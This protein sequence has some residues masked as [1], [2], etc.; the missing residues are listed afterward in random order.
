MSLRKSS[1]ERFDETMQNKMICIVGPTASGKTALSIA[2]AKE[3][4]AEIISG[5]S[6]QIYRGM[7]IGTAKPTEE[8]MDGV[9]HHMLSIAS[10]SENFSVARYV[11][12]ASCI[13]DDIISRGKIP[14][15]VGGTGLYI[16]SLVRGR[17]FAKNEESGALREELTKIYEK[18]GAD[19]LHKMLSELDPARAAEIHKNNVKRVIR[20]IEVCKLSGKTITEHDEETKKIPPKYDAAYIGIEFADRSALWE[21][22]HL[23]VDMMMAE[24]LLDEVKMLLDSGIST[25]TTAMQAIGYK[26]LCAYFAGDKTLADAVE[27]IKTA[28]RRYAKRQMTW[29]KRNGSIKWVSPDLS[30]KFPD[31]LQYLINFTSHGA[32]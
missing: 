27:D 14:I 2:L 16:D 23:R 28:T 4:N 19:A 8:E 22:I 10:P 5:D 26:E 21:R 30:E 24:G 29:F 7:D 6:M 18:D 12:E 3:M 32:V 15:V 20:A 11:E 25:D 31:I 17:M 13:A 1:K 9:P